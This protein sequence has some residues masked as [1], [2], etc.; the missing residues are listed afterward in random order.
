[1]RLKTIHLCFFGFLMMFSALAGANERITHY[2][3]DITIERNGD[4]MISETITANVEGKEIKR[5]IYRDIPTQYGSNHFVGFDLLSVERDGQSESYHT[6]QRRNGIRV[7]TGKRDV[8]LPVGEHR[9]T[10]RYRMSR[11]I[12]FKEERDELFFNAIGHGFIF[13]IDSADAFITLPKGTPILDTNVFTGPQGSKAQD[14]T[15]TQIGDELIK[16]TLDTPLDAYEGMSVAVAWPKGHVEAPSTK[17]TLQWALQDYRSVFI[18]LAGL[19]SLFT[20]LMYAWNKVGRDPKKQSVIARFTPP[21]GLSPGACNYILNRGYQSEALAAAMLNLVVKGY[22]DYSEPSKK[23][24]HF[25]RTSKPLTTSDTLSPGE[26]S[27]LNE[28]P[29]EGQSISFDRTYQKSIR[30]LK[31]RFQAVLNAEYGRAN[32]RD[33]S[34]YFAISI[35][36]TVGFLVVMII[37]SKDANS[38]IFGT[39]F[40]FTAAFMLLLISRAVVTSIKASKKRGFGKWFRMLFVIGPCAF[41]I[42]ETT[43]LTILSANSHP[44]MLAI[45]LFG[46]IATALVIL[47]KW[48]LEAPTIA[49]QRLIEQIEGFKLYLSVAEQDRLNFQYPPELTPELFEKYLPFAIALGVETE[50]GDQYAQHMQNAATSQEQENHDRYRSRF[51]NSNH[52]QGYSSLVRGLAAG[53]SSSIAAASTPPSSSSSRSGGFSSGSSSGGGGGGGGGGGW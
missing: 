22:Y 11:M 3:T 53:L 46:F 1:M 17:Q 36:I 30:S 5:G 31:N 43:P 13:P 41:L 18:G 7:Y 33:N 9:F 47:F 38:A 27:I 14:A 44:E 45:P 42:Y 12:A 32:F 50:W 37:T 52:R 51:H 35:A 24:Y 4:L 8:L 20:F 26:I 21:K 15:I 29:N 10:L 48:L 40:A 19:I 2:Q 6:E 16:Y 25:V 34:G 39:I 49:G 28:T 23:S